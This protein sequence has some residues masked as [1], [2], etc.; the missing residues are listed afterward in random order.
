MKPLHSAD[1]RG[2]QEIE[3]EGNREMGHVFETISACKTE[4][5]VFTL[6]MLI[7]NAI[8]TMSTIVQHPRLCECK[9][10]HKLV[11]NSRIKAQQLFFSR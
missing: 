2:H 1:S 11:C 7:S 3:C 6:R 8:L 9:Q 4:S 10:T 5:I